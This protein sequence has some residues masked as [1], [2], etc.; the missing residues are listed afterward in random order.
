MRLVFLSICLLIGGFAAYYGQ[1]YTKD[2]SDLITIMITVFTV[3]AGFLVAI[4]TVLGDPSL[5]PGD[6]WRSIES[7]REGLLDRLVLHSWLFVLYLVAIGF[8]FC[9]ALIEKAPTAVVTEN[10]KLWIDRAYLFFGVSAFAMSFALPWALLTIQT[11]RLDEEIERR[12]RAA[13]IKDG[14]P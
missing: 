11:S 9:G 6:G 3:F 13:G 1:P 4:V 2:N 7:R 14:E 5:V 10:V 8:L 12:R